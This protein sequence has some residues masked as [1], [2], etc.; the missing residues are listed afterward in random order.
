MNETLVT[1]LL[2]LSIV[3]SGLIAGV[4]FTFSAF[5]MCSLA[6]LPG[7][8]GARAM[9][10]I[11]VVIVRSPFILLFFGTTIAAAVLGFLGAWGW[12]EPWAIRT[13]AGGALYVL[14]MFGVTALRNVPLN[15]ALAAADPD[16]EEGAA[17]WR[18]YLGEWTRWNHLRTVA[19]TVT[20][21]VHVAAL[22]R[23]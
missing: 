6:E 3:G 5:V 20:C 2:W 9:N 12:G 8:D 10:R 4:Y 18:R 19:C 1:V 7:G 17:T 14:G 11:N 23:V 22:L 13:F 15:D 21:V 16:T